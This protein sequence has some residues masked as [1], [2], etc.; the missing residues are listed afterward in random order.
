MLSESL[1]LEDLYVSLKK[2][3]IE[4]K[5]KVLPDQIS[6]GLSLKRDIYCKKNNESSTALG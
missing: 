3:V 5:Q 2:L 4:D 1:P 6:H